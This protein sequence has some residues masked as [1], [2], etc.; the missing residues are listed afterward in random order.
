M[1]T[2][3]LPVGVM[4]DRALALYNTLSKKQKEPPAASIAGVAAKSV[5]RNTSART[6][7]RPSR[8][9]KQT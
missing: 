4:C 7:R 9:E 8:H 1:L 2:T 6:E 5:V 3:T